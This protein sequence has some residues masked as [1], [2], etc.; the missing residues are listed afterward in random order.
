MICPKNLVPGSKIAIVSPSGATI[1][2]FVKSAANFISNRGFEPVI[3]P[4]C[5]NRY[6]QFGGSDEQRLADMQSAM[7]DDSI[8]AILCSRGGYGAIRIV[9]K[10]DFTKFLKNPKWL[11]GFSDITNLHLALNRVG[12]MSIHGQMT[13]DMHEHPNSDAVKFV[14]DILKGETKEYLIDSND[15]NRI[16]AAETELI[17]GNISI[18]YS[19]QATKFEID[20]D[21]KI[22]FIEDLNEY[23]YHL[24][25][26]MINL[27][28]SGK[29]KNLK[30]LIVGA[31]T[32]MKDNPNPF[33]KTPYEIIND[34]VAEYSYPV[35][36]DFPTGHIENNLPLIC[37]R[38]Y[39]F[40]VSEK[41]VKLKPIA[42]N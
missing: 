18:L 3:Y 21:G 1:E 20:T 24:D 22:L 29:L 32:D 13:K 10:L 14:F 6:F 12:V 42:K 25:R 38:K 41:V 26:I 5:F 35:C 16:G 27:K 4:S 40:I 23:L 36:F 7:D 11:I 19:L 30:G 31:F 8:N 33:G 9:D 34:H 2:E 17:G 37:G 15:F 28:M 39:S